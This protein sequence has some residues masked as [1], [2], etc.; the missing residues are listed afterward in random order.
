MFRLLLLLRFYVYVLLIVSSTVCS[1]LSVRYHAVE[2]T[3]VIII[4]VPQNLSLLLNHI[5]CIG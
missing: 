2:M 5:G 3:V 4:T 1:P